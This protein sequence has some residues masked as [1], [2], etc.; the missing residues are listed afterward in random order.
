MT[1]SRVIAEIILVNIAITWAFYLVF[2]NDHRC[3]N[4]LGIQLELSKCAL[5]IA[6]SITYM[7]LEE[8]LKLY[9]AISADWV[10]EH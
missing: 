3:L 10:E 5:M 1:R 4:A 8:A 2:A 7:L 9:M 6:T